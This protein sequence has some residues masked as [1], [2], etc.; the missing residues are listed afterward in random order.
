M[1]KLQHMPTVRLGLGSQ[2]P[3]AVDELSYEPNL[4]L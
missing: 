4:Q 3:K 2:L 1:A